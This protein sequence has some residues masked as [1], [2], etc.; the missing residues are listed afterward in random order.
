MRSPSSFPDVHQRSHRLVNRPPVAHGEDPDHP[1]A[2]NDGVNDA[3]ASHAI[4]PETRQFPRE[5][6]TQGGITAE[7]LKGTLDSPLQVWGKM[8]NDLGNMGWDIEAIG[9]H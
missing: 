1:G 4:L 3:V 8:P 7:S 2:A 5:R 6:V 9:G